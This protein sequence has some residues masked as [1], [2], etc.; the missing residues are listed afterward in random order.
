M[1]LLFIHQAFPAQFGRLALELVRTRGWRCSFLVEALSS[2]PTPSPEMLENLELHPI[3]IS[4]AERDHTPTPWP[5]IYGKFLG[6]CRAVADA[7]RARP[8]LQPDLVVA[9]G[10][11]GAPT[12]FLPDLVRSPILNYCEYYFAPAY[13]DISY[14]IDLPPGAED[15]A[16]FFPRCINAPVLAAL[17]QADAGYSATHWQ[18]RTFPQRFWPKIDVHFDGIDT[19]FYRPHRA[20][21]PF[22]LGGRIIDRDTRVVTFVSRGLESVRGFDIFLQ[23]AERI[24]RERSDVLFVVAGSEDIYYGWDALRSGGK[25]F[26]QWAWGRT[27]L[28]PA[29]V[30]SLGQVSPDVLADVLSLSDVHIYLTV[31]FVLSWSLI[32]AMSTGLTVLASDVGPV[33]EV[34]DAGVHGLLEPIFDVERL[35]ETALRVL[36]D[37]AEFAPLGRA[38]RERIQERYSLETC[39]PALAH[40]FEGVAAHGSSLSRSAQHVPTAQSADSDHA[41]SE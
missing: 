3:P 1:H 5:Q 11:R 29:R 21:R 30:V 23:V 36:A 12:L 14:R 10:G 7:V 17:T 4:A 31:P 27:G 28:D 13:L 6:L 16:P 24:A 35:A 39:I 37:P 26:A 38:A 41:A 19:A 40:Y 8:E 15:V 9:H 18:K 32:N 20:Q 33:R 25:T 22:D 2:C 34:I